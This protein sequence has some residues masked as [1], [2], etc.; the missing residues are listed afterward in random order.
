[1]MMVNDMKYFIVIFIKI[2]EGASM[3]KYDV[4]LKIKMTVE[5]DENENLT[6]V[7]WEGLQNGECINEWDVID[8]QE[9][10]SERWW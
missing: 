5:V 7:I 9:K 8:V 6:D 4:E 2:E 3:K 10:E 1:M